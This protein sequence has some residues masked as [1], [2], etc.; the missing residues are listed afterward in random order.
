MNRVRVRSVTKNGLVSKRREN[1]P[2]DFPA[3][4]GRAGCFFIVSDGFSEKI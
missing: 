1:F 4:S 2:T 3:E